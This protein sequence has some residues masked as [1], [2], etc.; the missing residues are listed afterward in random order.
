MVDSPNAER[1]QRAGNVV[2]RHSTRLA[3]CLVFSE[4]HMSLAIVTC[5]W[6]LSHVIGSSSALFVLSVTPV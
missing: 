6:Q 2:K 1:A 3:A 4:G 5:H